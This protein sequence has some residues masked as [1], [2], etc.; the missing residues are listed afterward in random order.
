MMNVKFLL[1]ILFL[2][3]SFLGFSQEKIGDK[4]VDNNLTFDIV[5]DD[6]KKKGEFSFCIFD[7]LRATCIQNLSTGIEVKAYDSEGSLIWEGIA[8]GMKKSLKLPRPLPRARFITLVAF[9]PWV[10]NKTTGNLIH[11]D[12]PI[13]IKYYIK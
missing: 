6:I 8:T 3:L 4:W 5:K 7:T 13:E 2:N 1:S 9:K 12:K 10:A 11:Q